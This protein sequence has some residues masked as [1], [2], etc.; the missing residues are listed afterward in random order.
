MLAGVELDG[1]FG[2][3]VFLAI[4]VAFFAVAWLMVR[5]CDRIAGSADEPAKADVT[6]V[7]PSSARAA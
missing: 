3:V 2:D 7:E 6:V 1:L 5:A 4:T